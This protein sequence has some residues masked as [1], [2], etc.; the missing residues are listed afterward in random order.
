MSYKP[1]TVEDFE[2]TPEQMTELVEGA[3]RFLPPP[4]ETVDE[5]T[6]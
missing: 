1:L 4:T 6:E 5:P 2:L 3:Q